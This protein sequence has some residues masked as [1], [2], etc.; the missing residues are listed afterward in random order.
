MGERRVVYSV[1]WGNM[2]ERD[3]LED[4]DL[5]GRMILKCIFMKWNV[6][7]WIGSIWLRIA[8]GGRRVRMR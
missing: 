1:L 7:A 8:T 6:E 5:D 3:H 2:S 4:P